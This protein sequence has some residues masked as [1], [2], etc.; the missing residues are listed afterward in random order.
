MVEALGVP[1]L[2]L[3]FTGGTSRNVWDNKYNQERWDDYFGDDLK[4]TVRDVDLFRHPSDD[5][6]L[7]VAKAIVQRIREIAIL[8]CFVMMPY[9]DPTVDWLYHDVVLPAIQDAGMKPVRSDETLQPGR[10][11]EQMLDQVRSSAACVALVSD[12]KSHSANPNVMYEVGFAHAL[13]IPL[14]LLAETT[15]HLSFDVRV[16]RTI[17]YG[18][19]DKL[20]GGSKNDFRERLSQMLRETRKSQVRR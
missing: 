18:S 15:A 10:I 3:P 19:Y 9:Q 17:E 5:E 12:G 11:I 4:Q 7:E 13:N 2:P 8:Q 16:E 6:L 20:T 14:V 1:V